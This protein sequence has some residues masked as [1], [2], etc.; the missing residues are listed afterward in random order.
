MKRHCPAALQPC[1]SDGEARREGFAASV[2]VGISVIPH[3]YFVSRLL[4]NEG[5]N[6]VK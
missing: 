2:T 6:K 3:L 4:K 5:M 1:S